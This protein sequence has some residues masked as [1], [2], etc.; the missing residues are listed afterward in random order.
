MAFLYSDSGKYQNKEEP[1]KTSE[2]NHYHA[3]L[4]MFPGILLPFQQYSVLL[5]IQQADSG[6]LDAKKHYRND[7]KFSDTQVWANSADQ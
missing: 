3:K 5:I 7:P 2:K 1:L 4:R 6:G